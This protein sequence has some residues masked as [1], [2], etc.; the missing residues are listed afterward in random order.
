MTLRNKCFHIFMIC[1]LSLPF[2]HKGDKPR[3]NILAKSN[4]F[5]SSEAFLMEAFLM[6]AF[7]PFSKLR[8]PSSPLLCC[9]TTISVRIWFIWSEIRII[10]SIVRKSCLAPGNLKIEPISRVDQ[11][12]A[13]IVNA[14]PCYTFLQD[15]T[16]WFCISTYGVTKL[17]SAKLFHWPFPQTQNWER[18]CHFFVIKL[19]FS[20]AL[21]AFIIIIVTSWWN[22]NC[23][24]SFLCYFAPLLLL[25]FPLVKSWSF[26]CQSDWWQS[27]NST[28]FNS[29]QLQKTK[30]WCQ[31]NPSTQ[32]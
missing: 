21:S 29:E 15:K 7:L 23:L 8:R 14:V 2:F 31:R 22:F 27:L 28:V 26:L 24:C 1:L 5:C 16:L 19:R 10:V 20:R 17:V 12:I 30:S 4:W 11:K 32:S 3:S 9:L 6:E 25:S 13:R 18:I